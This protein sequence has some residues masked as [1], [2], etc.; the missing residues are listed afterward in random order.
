MFLKFFIAGEFFLTFGLCQDNIWPI[1]AEKFI[2][3]VFGEERP[4]RYHTGIDVRT[5][6]EIGHPLLAINNLIRFTINDSSKLTHTD[7]NEEGVVI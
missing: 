4:N 1:N 7:N 3:A 6:G 5:F 2:T